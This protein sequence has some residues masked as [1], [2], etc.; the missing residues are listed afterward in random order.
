MRKITS[1]YI[2]SKTGDIIKNGIIIIDDNNI[3]ID[4]ID[5]KGVIKEIENL[6]YYSGIICPAFIDTMC[7]LSYPDYNISSE[8]KDI[9]KSIEIYKQNTNKNHLQTKRAIN[10]LDAFGT[11]VAADLFGETLSLEQTKNSKAKIITSTFCSFIKQDSIIQNKHMY[12]YNTILCDKN[13][14]P[15]KSNF[16]NIC[17]ST[18]SI[19]SHNKLSIF[20][21]MINI[22]ML[23]KEL[24]ISDIVRMATINGAVALGIDKQ[25]GSIEINKIARLNIISNYDIETFK[26]KK[27]S[28]IKVLI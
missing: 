4:I 14:I 24:D 28:K 22:Q 16:L 8:T 9:A 25:Y 11:A 15:L 10:H 2:V 20:K 13:V 5:T 27:D 23:N 18:G 1:N 26:L 6:E 21:E 7:F 19:M 12:I 17:L 3:I